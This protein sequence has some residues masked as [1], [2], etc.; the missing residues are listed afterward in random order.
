VNRVI[1]TGL[2]T[3]SAFVVLLLVGGTGFFAL[4]WANL[5]SKECGIAVLM[6]HQVIPDQEVPR[7]YGARESDLARQFEELRDAG[8]RL[9]SEQELL[10]FLYPADGSRADASWE[11]D[12][13]TN[14]CPWDGT[15]ALV[16]FDMDG[17]SHH[18][19]LVL[20]HLERHE[21]PALF[22]VP[23]GFLDSGS[24]VTSADVQALASRGM[25]FGSHSEWHRNLTTVESDSLV[26]SLR[27]S[28][29][30]LRGLSGQEVPTVAAPG[31]RYDDRVLRDAERAGFQAFFN[32]DP[33]YVTSA[34]SP[35]RLCRIE[36]R[37]D[38]GPSALQAVQSTRF[39]AG[40]A[41]SWQMRRWVE[42]MV[43]RRAWSWLS[44]QRARLGTRT[45][46]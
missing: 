37:G 10:A 39:V 17:T 29:D 20:P 15:A 21:I 6:F 13:L 34:T 24:A 42:R 32:S 3:G 19:E 43:G 45:G 8:V 33:C 38:R 5:A 44:S 40:Q 4:N 23:T 11:G 30:T 7:R 27:R 25:A 28:R 14:G 31:G 41:T 12:V 2:V 35:Y 18:T 36:I 22:F 9:L 26:A 46:Y 1:R 16:T